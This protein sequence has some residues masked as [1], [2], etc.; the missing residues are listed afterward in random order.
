MT[1]DELITQTRARTQSL[2]PLDLLAGAARRQQELADVGEKLLDHFVQQARAAGCSW[3]QIGTALGVSKQAAQQRHSALRSL[4]GKI[5][6]GV[7]SAMGH[8]VTRFTSRARRAVV[9]GQEEARTL[10]HD[11]IGTEHLLLGLLAEGEGIAA[12]ALQHAGITLDAV[13]AEIKDVVGCAEEMPRGHIPFTPRAKKVLELGLREALHLGHNF[14][15]TEH[16]LLGI[17]REGA[18]VAAQ[19]LVKLGA[20]LD[21]LRDHVLAVLAPAEAPSGTE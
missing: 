6:G 3:S 10:R 15:G 20:D 17:I 4:V 5:V 21:Q 11:H 9:L 13:R 14:L 19:A 7:E 18:G 16:I 8:V 2:N 1:L 12:Q